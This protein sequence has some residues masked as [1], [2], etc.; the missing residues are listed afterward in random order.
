MPRNR[1]E[2]LQQLVGLLR[3][4]FK[5]YVGQDIP[6][7]VRV[8][9]GWPSGKA[10]VTKNRALAECFPRRMSVE[11]YNEIFMSP[12]VA[13]PMDVAAMLVH[14]LVHAVDDCVN[15]H[16]GKF[17]EFAKA[18]GLRRPWTATTPG[19]ALSGVLQIG[20]AHV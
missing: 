2:W 19:E 10:M 20:R 7:K 16:K 15:S 17:I 11:G 9:C 5:E 12:A 8:S 3:P 4:Y 1:E 18:A 6:E 14:E 13:D